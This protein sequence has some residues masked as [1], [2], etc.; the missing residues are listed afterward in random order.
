M[1]KRNLIT[2]LAAVLMLALLMTLLAGCIRKKDTS[3]PVD[4]AAP[5]ET[6][7]A[8]EGEPPAA[9]V[10]RQDGERFEATIVMEGME[11]TVRYEHI[12]S[13]KLGF[14]MDYDYENFERQSKDGFERFVSVYDDA[15]NPENYLDVMYN[16]Q[17]AETVAAGVSAALSVDYEINRE[18]AFELE[19]AGKCIRI[20][21]SADVGGQTMPDQLMMV[22]IIPAEDGCRVATAHYAIEASEGFGH[23]FHYMMDTLAVLAAQGDNKLSDEQALEAI[24]QYCYV[25][26]P[27]L[28]EIVKAGEHPV[29]WGV[30]EKDSKLVVLF[31]SY[32]GAEIRYYIDPAS[33]EATVTELVPAVS[34]E[35]QQTD[36]TLNVWNYLF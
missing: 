1:K 12:R 30:D 20:D 18:D 28:K 23:R 25:G 19:R 27:D 9:P 34:S 29:Y 13:D 36:E 26:N 6:S 10:E 5:T 7:E 15:E 16:P 17:D 11:E 3:E 22:Y 8:S 24:E 21:A 33:G 4:T 35:E 14:E 32:T 31:K 2:V